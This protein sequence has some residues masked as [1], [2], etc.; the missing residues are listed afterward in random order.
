MGKAATGWQV[1]LRGLNWADYRQLLDARV[2][3]GR[4]AIR[5]TYFRGQAEIMTVSN[6]HERWKKLLALL[7]ET[8]L[9]ETGIPF[10]PSGGITLDREDV[11]S[12]FEPD[13]CYYIRNAAR[14]A[15]ARDLDFTVDPP[16]DLAVEIEVSRTV[17][18]RLPAYAS[19]GVPEVWRFDGEA[20]TVLVLQPDRTYREAAASVALPLFP[21]GDVPGYLQTAETSDFGTAVRRFRAQ[22]RQSPP[23]QQPSI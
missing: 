12:G 14:A 16:P 20:V 8:Y 15:G 18:G 5:I 7:I 4:R 17:V 9:I 19:L 1:V 23:P 2:A 3:A 22:V 10:N 6:P 11:D 13:E 21:L